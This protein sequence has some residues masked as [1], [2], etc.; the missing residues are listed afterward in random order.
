MESKS[1]LLG[2]VSWIMVA[3][4]RGQPGEAVRV[5]IKYT[6]NRFANPARPGFRTAAFGKGGGGRG[7]GKREGGGGETPEEWGIGKPRR[8]ERRG[9]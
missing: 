9:G 5:L 3:S 6:S 1:V 8:G 4:T 7:W 2:F